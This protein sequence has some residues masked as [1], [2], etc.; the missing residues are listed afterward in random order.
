VDDRL[1]P[2]PEED[3]VNTLTQAIADEAT[4]HAEPRR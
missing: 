1:R 3:I 2:V 4:K